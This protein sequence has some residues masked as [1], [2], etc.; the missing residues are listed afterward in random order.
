MSDLLEDPKGIAFFN[1][2][3][4][5]THYCR[6]EP[7][8]AAYLN[9]SD[10]GINASRGQDFKWRL[11]ADWVKRV[12]EFRR[13]RMQMQLLSQ[14]H[15]G[16]KPTTVQILYFLYGEDLRAYEEQSDEE[17]SPFEQQY[18]QDIAD[19]PKATPVVADPPAS[20]PNA[21]PEPEDEEEI[22]TDAAAEAAT[23]EPVK[24]KSQERREAASKPQSK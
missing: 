7:T 12:R 8:I 10:M 3:S 2:E 24:S 23:S 22:D 13:D 5:D 18:Q 6:L 4:G 19:K 21:D 1:I 14:M 17:G 9:S 11:G 16:Q 15:D 20:L